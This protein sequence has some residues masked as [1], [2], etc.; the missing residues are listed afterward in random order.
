MEWV[1]AVS[2][3][4]NLLV[5]A[6]D[7]WRLPNRKELQ[8]LL[9]FSKHDPAIDTGYFPNTMSPGYWSST[10]FANDADVAWF[11]IFD[12]GNDDGNIKP[13]SYYVRAV[14]GGQN[15]ISGHLFIAS[16]SQ[17]SGWNVGTVMPITW[18]TQSIAGNVSITLSRDGG[19]TYESITNSSENDG[20]YVWI[21][22][23]PASVNC[24]LKIEPLNDPSKGTTQGLFTIFNL[25]DGLVAYYPFNGNANDESG[26]GNH[27]MVTGAVLAADRFGNTNSA[28]N[29]DGASNIVVSNAEDLSLGTFTISVWFLWRS[30][31]STH[32]Y[33]TVIAKGHIGE[34]YYQNFMIYVDNLTK[35]VR[36][37][38]GHNM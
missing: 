2:Y 18:E 32:D 9:D 12:D 37:R 16:P 30:E 27:G 17:A 13:H 6:Y 22:T 24:M 11:V 15:Q 25:N 5:A 36:A 38:V 14:R 26:N 19:Q 28:Y 34:G 35:T 33:R 7:D 31:H 21:V 23:G 1:S 8:S 20:S 4:E 3:C 10:I 29:F